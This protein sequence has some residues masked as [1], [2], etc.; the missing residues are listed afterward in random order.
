VHK[1]LQDGLSRG[2]NRCAKFNLNRIRES[3][4]EPV[5][6]CDKIITSSLHL[7]I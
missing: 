7:G 1:I 2:H 4:C 6:L 5:S 3:T